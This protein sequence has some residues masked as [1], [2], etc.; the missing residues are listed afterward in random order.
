MN[1]LIEKICECW[2]CVFFTEFSFFFVLLCFDG[3]MMLSVCNKINKMFTY[4]WV[5]GLQ[6]REASN[7]NRHTLRFPRNNLGVLFGLFCV[8]NLVEAFSFC[9]VVSPLCCFGFNWSVDALNLWNAD[10][11]IFFFFSL[12]GRESLQYRTAQNQTIC[13]HLSFP[14]YFLIHC[15][16]S[17]L[18]LGRI[19]IKGLITTENLFSVLFSM[20]Q[21]FSGKSDLYDVSIVRC[22]IDSQCLPIGSTAHW[23]Y[24]YV[25]SRHTLFIE[26][27]IHRLGHNI[28]D[29]D[30]DL[31]YKSEWTLRVSI[32]KRKKIINL[33][34]LR[35]EKWILD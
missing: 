30:S 28:G 14:I 18:R 13:Y 1:S 21:S 8:R 25:Q 4:Y 10:R 26:S 12:S 20:F 17:F 16:R 22:S 27:M 34:Y 6:T 31:F 2:L 23:M 3:T 29:K 19:S 35:T 5:S 33:V 11:D 9:K 32:V 24:S 15:K 7:Q